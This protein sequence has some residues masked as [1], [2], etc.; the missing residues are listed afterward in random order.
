MCAFRHPNMHLSEQAYKGTS[1]CFFF[2]TF[3]FYEEIHGAWA[4][5]L[6]AHGNK[7][8]GNMHAD[9]DAGADCGLRV[10]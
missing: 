9:T 10:H 8:F 1:T 2:Q 3:H 6:V 4:Q 5:F 7:L